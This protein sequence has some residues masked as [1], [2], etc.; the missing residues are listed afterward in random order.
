MD[1][2]HADQ[3][4]AMLGVEVVHVGDVLEVVGI[5]FAGLHRLVG[6]VVVVILHDLQGDALLSQD[7]RHLFQNFRVGSGGGAHLEGDGIAAFV[8]AAAAG[9]QGQAGRAGQ[10]QGKNF[11]FHSCK[12]L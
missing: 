3:M 4:G 10:R 12:L 5:I 6:N 2:S 1:L 9:Q 7:G 8:I 11:L